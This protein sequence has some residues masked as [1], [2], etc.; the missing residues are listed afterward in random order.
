VASKCAS[1]LDQL[2]SSPH[3][4]GA[5]DVIACSRLIG[6]MCVRALKGEAIRGT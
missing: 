1:G 3:A 5:G 6:S 2:W 4:A